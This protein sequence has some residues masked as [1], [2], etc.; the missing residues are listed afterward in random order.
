MI[1]LTFILI[2]LLLLCILL[3][4]RL[5]WDFYF[6]LFSFILLFYYF[7]FFRSISFTWLLWF[8]SLPGAGN[9]FLTLISRLLF[10]ILRYLRGPFPQLWHW[11]VVT[12]VFLL[13]WTTRFRSGSIVRWNIFSWSPTRLRS[14]SWLHYNIEIKIIQ[15][16]Y[17]IM[18]SY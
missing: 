16:I 8:I 12:C 4:S 5:I 15:I 7:A 6:W 13:C 1:L 17:I 3:F 18:L 14:R 9:F 11:S 10:T 2:L